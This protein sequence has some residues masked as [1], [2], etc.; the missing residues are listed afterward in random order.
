MSVMEGHPEDE[1]DRESWPLRAVQ[2]SKHT[3][4][5]SL[6]RQEPSRPDCCHG[7]QDKDGPGNHF[8]ISWHHWRRRPRQERRGKWDTQVPLY[9]CALQDTQP[10]IVT[11]SHCSMQER[12]NKCKDKQNMFILSACFYKDPSPDNERVFKW[13][14]YYRWFFCLRNL[15][16]ELTLK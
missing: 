16:S 1:L 11:S 15:I 14:F 3:T 8:P 7:S 9:S 2:I 12:P 10:Q 6:L 13:Y 5:S 4:P